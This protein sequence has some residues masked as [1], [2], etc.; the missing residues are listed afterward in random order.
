[1]AGGPFPWQ[2][3]DG[4][5]ERGDG[6]PADLYYMV[7]AHRRAE[8][9]GNEAVSQGDPVSSLWAGELWL[10]ASVSILLSDR[11]G[12]LHG[13]RKRTRVPAC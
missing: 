10:W 4:P 5:P 11:T 6:A 12:G 8:R 13:S 9:V 3:L 2:T 7:R 1:M